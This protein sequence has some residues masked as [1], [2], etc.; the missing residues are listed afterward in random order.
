MEKLTKRVEQLEKV[1]LQIQ[2]HVAVLS[3]RSEHFSTKADIECLR[4][5]QEQMR[6]ALMGEISQ[7]TK[8]L[9]EKF[10]ARFEKVDTR[11]D[12]MDARF[13]K[14]DA[15]FDKMN[16]RITWTLMIPAIL[17]VLAWFVK[18]AVLKS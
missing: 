2:Q 18:E 6:N 8:G 15:R 16:D 12:K 17:A 5:E 7:S 9:E 13:D 1:T 4:T 10:N 14:M 11:F 3:A